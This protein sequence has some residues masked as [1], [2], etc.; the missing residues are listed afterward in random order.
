MHQENEKDLNVSTAPATV[1]LHGCLSPQK[2]VA[3][4]KKP[5]IQSHHKHDDLYRVTSFPRCQTEDLPL[6][7][8]NERNRQADIEESADA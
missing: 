6:S 3:S 8:N 4:E 1:H 2:S 5:Y 7:S